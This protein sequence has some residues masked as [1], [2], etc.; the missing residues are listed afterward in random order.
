MPACSQY[1]GMA[2]SHWRVPITEPAV[3]PGDMQQVSEHHQPRPLSS[4]PPTPCCCSQIW[5]SCVPCSSTSRLR[6]TE[7]S[8]FQLQV[9]CQHRK[10]W[11]TLESSRP[12]GGGFT[13]AFKDITRAM[14][15]EQL[16]PG[17]PGGTEG[18]L[19]RYMCCSA[20]NSQHK[21]RWQPRIKRLLMTY[22]LDT[23]K[24][25]NSDTLALRAF[26]ALE[27]NSNLDLFCLQPEDIKGTI[28][29]LILFAISS[30]HFIAS[31]FSYRFHVLLAQTFFVYF[32]NNLL[33][34]TFLQPSSF[35]FLPISCLCLG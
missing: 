25:I 28:S 6:N 9:S 24:W 10:N 11:E 26:L 21:E 30:M 16:S 14:R 20:I 4:C 3:V 19:S 12:R 27:I 31:L 32:S 1:L 33:I 22:I 15:L 29:P 13:Q 8:F 7:M 17:C 2:G 23:E 34:P 5:L 35:F 18:P